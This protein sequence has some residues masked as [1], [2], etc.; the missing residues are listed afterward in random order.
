M[1]LYCFYLPRGELGVMHAYVC[2]LCSYHKHG[3]QGTLGIEHAMLI[4]QLDNN[5]YHVYVG[6]GVSIKILLVHASTAKMLGLLVR[7]GTYTVRTVLN[8]IAVFNFS[9]RL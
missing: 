4:L 7:H 2:N 1:A 6:N 8:F 3:Q 9:F 5:R